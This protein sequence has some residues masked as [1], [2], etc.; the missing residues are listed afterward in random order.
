[1]KTALSLFAVACLA[2]SLLHAQEPSIVET[3]FKVFGNCGM[4]KTRIEKAVSMKEVRHAKWN[5]STKML[6]VA[7][8][9]GKV[10]VD[11]LQQRVA[12]VGHDTERFKA[13]DSVYASL[14]QCCLYRGGGNT[15]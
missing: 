3:Q 11:S 14:P 1:M 4:C 9:S 10:T 5:K 12:A 2:A 13:P 7:Y 8:L 15:H 6:N